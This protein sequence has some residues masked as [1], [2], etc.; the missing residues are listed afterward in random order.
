MSVLDVAARKRKASM[1]NASS[2]KVEGVTVDK[3]E[4]GRAARGIFGGWAAAAVAD[5][6]AGAVCAVV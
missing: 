6:T 1:S 5:F 3:K 2:A 4:E